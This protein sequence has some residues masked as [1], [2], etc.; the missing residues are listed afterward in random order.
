MAFSEI[1]DVLV[2]RRGRWKEEFPEW[3]KGQRGKKE[4]GQA[5]IHPSLMK[6]RLTRSATVRK[7]MSKGRKRVGRLAEKSIDG[8]RATKGT[9]GS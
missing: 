3:R 1:A 4:S 2:S 5:E 9:Y 7:H 6:S 8:L